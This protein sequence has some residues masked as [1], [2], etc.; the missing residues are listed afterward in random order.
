MNNNQLNDLVNKLLPVLFE[1]DQQRAC[2]TVPSYCKE[3]F[4][5][6]YSDGEYVA[7]K[8]KQLNL[9][10][11]LRPDGDMRITSLDA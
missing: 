11:F 2:L 4:K 7:N 9:A 3:I 1:R 8:L 5:M 6:T 10:Y